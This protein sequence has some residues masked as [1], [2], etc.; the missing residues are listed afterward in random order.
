[1]IVIA[2]PK[3]KLPVILGDLSQAA[4]ITYKEY[5]INSETIRQYSTTFNGN[6]YVL[7]VDYIN[8][9]GN[10]S[11]NILKFYKTGA[12][13]GIPIEFSPEKINTLNTADKL[14][15]YKLPWFEFKKFIIQ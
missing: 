10:S 12:N 15:N 8:K 4:L 2:W 7:G 9:P 11:G 5:T 14:H 3:C 13:T 6:N 1:M